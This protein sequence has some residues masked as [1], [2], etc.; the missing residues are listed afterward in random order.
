M[1]VCYLQAFLRIFC[2]AAQKGTIGS[3]GGEAKSRKSLQRS[4][5]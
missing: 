4:E 3:F 1:V 2:E 5:A